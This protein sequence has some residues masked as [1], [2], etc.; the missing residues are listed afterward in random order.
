[1]APRFTKIVTPGLKPKALPLRIRVTVG[2]TAVDLVIG[3]EAPNSVDIDC[4]LRLDRIDFGFTGAGVS[5]LAN[6]VCQGACPRAGRDWWPDHR[7]GDPHS[8]TVGW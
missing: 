8:H 7:H 1:M 5:G 2:L 6:T 3:A 4:A